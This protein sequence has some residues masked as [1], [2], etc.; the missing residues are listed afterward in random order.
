MLCSSHNQDTKD[1]A[2]DIPWWKS[3]QLAL[4]QRRA[5]LRIPEAITAVMVEV[6]EA[7]HS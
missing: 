7:S 4:Y 2:Q 5:I 3:N 1:G 6:R